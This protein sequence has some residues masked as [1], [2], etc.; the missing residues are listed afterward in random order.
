MYFKILS[1]LAKKR[2]NSFSLEWNDPWTVYEDAE[3]ND[4]YNAE[5]RMWKLSYYTKTP[6]GF[7]IL[8]DS[9]FEVLMEGFIKYL[10]EFELLSSEDFDN[11][12]DAIEFKLKWGR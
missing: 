2:P 5:D 8:E 10:V 9:D 3:F 1:T 6:V 4:E 11:Q 7:I 12:S